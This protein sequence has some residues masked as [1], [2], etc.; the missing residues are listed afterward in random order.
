MHSDPEPGAARR[1]FRQVL[2]NEVVGHGFCIRSRAAK[3]SYRCQSGASHIVTCNVHLRWDADLRELE[4]VVDGNK[5]YEEKYC[6]IRRLGCGLKRRREC[7][8]FA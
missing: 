4:A 7:L 5:E 2:K 1:A 3:L 8:N 6:H